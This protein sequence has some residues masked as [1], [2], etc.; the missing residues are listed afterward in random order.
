MKYVGATDWF[1]RWPFIIEGMILGISGAIIST[2]V[3]YYVYE[4]V[5]ESLL[6]YPR[7]FRIYSNESSFYIKHNFMAVYIRWFNYWSN[8]KYNIHKKILSCV[9]I[10]YIYFYY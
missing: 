5:F 8:W 7:I 1:I 3:L 10:K 2:G 6:M 9:N 4:L